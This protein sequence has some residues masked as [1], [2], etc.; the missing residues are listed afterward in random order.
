MAARLRLILVV[1]DA[2]FFL[3]HRLPIALAARD[4]GYEVE[5]ATSD[6]PAVDE[7][8]RQGFVHHRIAMIR[9][10]AS[11]I[12]DLHTILQLYGLF[13]SRRPD[14][15]HLVTIKPVLFG[16][17]AARL[18]GVPSVVAAVT[19]LGPGFSDLSI[20]GR[21]VRFIIG[22]L[23]RLALRHRHLRA[24]FQNEDDKNAILS[25]AMIN[26]KNA[27]VLAGSGVDL[28]AFH[29]TPEPP[30]PKTA[31]MAC[32]LLR[33]KGVT[34]F[35]EAARRLRSSGADYRF[36]IAGDIDE[37]SPVSFERDEVAAL[38]AD[39]TA[40]FVG[41]QQDVRQ[42]FANAH[43]V[44]QPTTF[45]EGFPKVL[46]EAAAAGRATITTDVPGCRDAIEP[47]ETGLLVPPG[48][49]DALVGAIRLLLENATKRQAMALAGR[50][51]AERK[52]DV[53]FIVAAH[54]DLY[55]SLTGRP[56]PTPHSLHDS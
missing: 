50:A 2:G 14:L 36:L 55:A 9:R 19:G 12:G 46:A 29:A 32:R 45:R 6:G 17:I 3:S 21:L 8:A 51:L 13:R 44:V 47:N 24:I 23:Y 41:P 25:L 7:I 37:G 1:N 18:A 15:V 54:L 5:I 31:V 16:G 42:L 26:D 39:G 20:R 56:V 28:N 49:V 52:F 43:I 10:S 53:R 22:V 40:A 34:E 35:V 33:D 27:L 48:D 38:G 30:G 11:P 4:A